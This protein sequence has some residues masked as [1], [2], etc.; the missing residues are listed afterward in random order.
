MRDQSRRPEPADKPFRMVDITKQ[1][2]TRDVIAHQ[3]YKRNLITGTLEGVI[4]AVAPI[5]IASGLFELGEA[6]D[7]VDSARFPLVREAA[8]SNGKVVI[9]GSSL[10]GCVRS[11]V[12]AVTA[13][14]ISKS[15]ANTRRA[16]PSLNECTVN[17]RRAEV[18]P[19]C[20]IF[21][22]MGYMGRVQ[23]ADA[24][25]L[26]GS[27]RAV[28][29]PALF[30]PRGRGK[31]YEPSGSHGM[32]CRKFYF[33]HKRAATGNIPSEVCEMGSRFQLQIKVSNLSEAELGLLL[34]VLAQAESFAIKIGGGRPVGYGG[35][36][37]E[38]TKL[39]TNR[40]DRYTSWDG[41]NTDVVEGPELKAHI[42]KLTKAAR[43]SLLIE[44]Q[45][46]QLVNIL[47]TENNPPVGMY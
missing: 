25:M 15:S 30:G 26:S 24:Q 10:K 1:K 19:A 7:S 47:S 43:Q 40:A 39:V 31:A 14:C 37:I 28:Q 4:E 32:G 12:E 45:F 38:L 8:R 44:Q 27:V 21:G 29:M 3:T 41:K 34:L 22:A 16:S 9:P 6:L 36:K 5:Q 42:E 11:M 17:A 20:A 46:R 2:N 33:N 18:C 13:S 23:I 35:A